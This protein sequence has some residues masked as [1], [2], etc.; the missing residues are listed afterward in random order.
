MLKINHEWNLLKHNEEVYE[1]DSRRGSF[2]I[3]KT[4]NV[5][6]ELEFKD[7]TGRTKIALM[8]NIQEE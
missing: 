3:H 4:D 7:I 8:L 6:K 5:N 2:Y 1:I